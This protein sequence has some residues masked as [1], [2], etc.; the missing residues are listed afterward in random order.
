MGLGLQGDIRAHARVARVRWAR[1][2]IRYAH[3]CRDLSE[4]RFPK[5]DLESLDTLD[6]P[7]SGHKKSPVWATGHCN[8][9]KVYE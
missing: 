9:V 4:I 6:T 2:L 5:G 8:K 7:Q 3:A 1:A